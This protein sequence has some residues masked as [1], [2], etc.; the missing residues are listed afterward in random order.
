[1]CFLELWIALPG[2]SR[3][4][5]WSSKSI[6]ETV[7][8]N[9]REHGRPSEGHLPSDVWSLE[10]HLGPMSLS[11]C[12]TPGISSFWIL[13]ISPHK[14]TRPGQSIYLWASSRFKGRRRACFGM[15]KNAKIFPKNFVKMQSKWPWLSGWFSKLLHPFPCLWAANL[16]L[17]LGRLFFSSGFFEKDFF[18][19]KTQYFFFAKTTY[20]TLWL[21][22]NR[23]LL[24]G[25]CRCQIDPDSYIVQQPIAL[26]SLIRVISLHMLARCMCL[27]WISN[28]PS[29]DTSTHLMSSCFLLSA[30]VLFLLPLCLINFGL[31]HRCMPT[32]HQGNHIL[33]ETT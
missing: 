29:L 26:H 1:M 12:K 22:N 13:T 28:H 4:I 27:S 30:S 10:R 14:Q 33:S 11:F 21:L 20:Q 15:Q 9:S 19:R 16:W 6:D 23:I 24:A 17:T 25:A 32:C 2:S 18:S 8:L 5:L 3:T 31:R 7:G